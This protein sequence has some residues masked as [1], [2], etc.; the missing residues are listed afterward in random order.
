MKK[1]GFGCMRLP[2][3]EG[4]EGMEREVDYEQFNQ[5][6]DRFLEEGFN[7]FDTAHGYVE[8]KSELALRECLVKRY[9]REAYI[10]TDKLTTHFFKK[11][12]EI[13]PLFELQLEN[14]GVEYF[15]YY[16][17]HAMN[18]DFYQKYVK[19]HA[20][21][22]VRQL[23]EE[24][25]IKHIGL[26]FHDKAEVLEEI[27]REQPDVEVVQIQFNY[28][29][30]DDPG[31]ESYKCYQICEKYNK[32]VIV[33]EPVKG[34]V[35]VNLPEEAKKL[36]SDYNREASYASYAIRYCASFEKVFMVLSGMSTAEQ[37]EDNIGY[38]KE[39]KPFTKEEYNIVDHIRE[40]LKGQDNIACT[41]CKYCIDECPKSIPIP[42]LFACNNAK[43]QFKDWNSEWYYGVYTNG[44][45]KAADCIKCGK[46]ETV[47]PQ[48]LT[49]RDYLEEVSGIFDRK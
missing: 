30:Y 35:L 29:D 44:K 24:G 9:P 41:A 13:R 12:E 3:K 36:L 31:I 23:K 22:I 2:M 25:K 8:G 14:A 4:N 39:F 18:R 17:M 7:Y 28:A 40:M 6:I 15:D 33:M 26:S 27:L 45:G 34:G 42:D 49:I 38:M 10:L 19:C 47:C 20:F 21:E 11:E 16:L 32:P 43:K 37:M 48:H 46:C 1:L 5:M